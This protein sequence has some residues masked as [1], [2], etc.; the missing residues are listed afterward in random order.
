MWNAPTQEQLRQIPKIYGT[1]SIP[2]ADKTIHLHLFIGGC[3]WYIT[4]YDGEDL[5]FGFACL[6]DIQNAE[7][8]YISLTELKAVSTHGIEVDCDLYWNK[9]PA[10]E[11]DIIS[12]A[13]RWDDLVLYD[14]MEA[15]HV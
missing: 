15:C 5:M 4:E 6:G 14:S 7:W 10:S 1:E 12:K 13:M 11:V 2:L 3:D 9:C 8:G